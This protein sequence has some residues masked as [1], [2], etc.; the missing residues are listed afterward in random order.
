MQLIQNR[1]GRY[2]FSRIERQRSRDGTGVDKGRRSMIACRVLALSCALALCALT[3]PRALAQTDDKPPTTD[4]RTIYVSSSLGSDANSGLSESAPKRTLAAGYALLRNHMPDR[5]LLRRGD[6]WT[7]EQPHT[8]GQTWTRN[9]Y[10]V[11]QPV[12]VGAYGSDPRR[13]VLRSGTL[14]DGVRFQSGAG[15][16]YVLFQDLAFIAD[17]NATNAPRGIY[18]WAAGGHFTMRGCRVEGFAI[19]IDLDA[20]TPLAAGYFTLDDCQILDAFPGPS[21][22]G[23]S[24]GIYVAYVH[25]VLVDRCVIDRCGYRYPDRPPTIFNHGC[26]FSQSATNVLIRDSIVARASATGI[27]LRGQRMD[28]VRNLVLSCPLGITMGHPQQ[29]PD[30]LSRGY[31]FGNLILDSGDIGWGSNIAPRGFGIAWGETDHASITDNIVAHGWSQSGHEP[32]YSVSDLSRNVVFA[33]N[34]GLDWRGCIFG[35]RTV[36]FDNTYIGQNTFVNTPGRCTGG[37]EFE[38][39]VPPDVGGTW[40]GNNYAGGGWQMFQANAVAAGINGWVA[41]TDDVVEFGDT[42]YSNINISLPRYILEEATDYP[43][44][45]DVPNCV[46]SFMSACRSRQDRKDPRFT[47]RSVIEWARTRLGLAPLGDQPPLP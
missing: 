38:N 35:V 46:D 25:D 23:H 36:M 6:T 16:R 28:A 47:S 20:P 19:N 30:Q 32:A 7:G 4:I 11:A 33:R 10:S 21:G 34:I 15:V 37:L 41:R 8:T 2:V 18:W 9:G 27:Q 40:L 24:Q 39:G 42:G 43:A 13:P 31:I 26:Y 5:M 45:A 44:Y 17:R 29:T 3:V 14:S 22:T 12:V 1:I